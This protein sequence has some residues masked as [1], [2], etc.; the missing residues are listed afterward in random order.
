[1]RNYPNTHR[2]TRWNTPSTQEKTMHTKS[3]IAFTAGSLVTASLAFLIATGPDHDQHKD[4]DMN[5]MAQPETDPAGMD[6][7]AAMAKLAT[8]DEHHQALSHLVGNWTAKTSFVMDPSGPPMT[9][10]GTMSVKWVLGGRY[11]KS[12]FSMDFMGQ[13]FQSIGYTGYDIAHE[14]Y[15]STWMDTMSTKITS[16]TGDMDENGTLT[17][18]GIATTPMGDNPMKIVSTKIDENTVTDNFYDQMPDGSWFNSATITYTR[19]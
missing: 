17:L 18:T 12:D 13:P 3:L 15:I 19:D 14:Q 1:M 11:I 4:H 10:Q 16:T 5:S 6:M 7:A 2:L 8:P 9:G